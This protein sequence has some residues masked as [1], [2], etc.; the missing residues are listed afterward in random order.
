MSYQDY[1]KLR[2]KPDFWLGLIV[3]ILVLLGLIMI[4]SSSVVVSFEK[5]GYNTYF[6]RKQFWSLLVG[7]A[8]W[9][10]ALNIDYRFWK[11]W[12]NWMLAITLILLLAVFIPG[13]GRNLSGAQRWIH[14]GPVFFQPSEVV[15][16]TFL[17]YLCSWLEKKGEGIKNFSTGVL[18]FLAIVGL[19]TILILKQPDMGTMMVVAATSAIVLFTSGASRAHI[20]GI[21]AGA[22]VLVLA[23]IKIAPYRL[24]RLTVFLNPNEQTQGVAYHINQAL[25]AVG[26]GGFW[27]LGFGQSR[28]KYL[29]LPQ[30]YTDSIF[31]IIAEEMGFLRTTLIILLFVCLGLRG[32]KIAKN[33]PDD[34]SRFLAVGITGWFLFQGFVNIGAMLGILPLTGIPLPFI[35]YGGTSLVVSLAAVGI[36]MNISK[37]TQS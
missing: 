30:S 10:V 36:L 20:F 19:I 32:F 33:A 14:I 24:Q 16:L 4:S 18:P 21:F 8:V 31:A 28:Q 5:F 34:F 6:L 27:G 2:P 11:K 23:M 7:F 9:V 3:L 26:S 22:V 15:K 13:I 1:R 37:Q 17:I 35:S 29:Y 25:L 12:A